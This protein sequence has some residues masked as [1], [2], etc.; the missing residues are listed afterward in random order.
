M[1]LVRHIKV[2]FLAPLSTLRPSV[3]NSS[4]WPISPQ[5]KSGKQ[6]F[7]KGRIQA[8]ILPLERKVGTYTLFGFCCL[9]DLA[10]TNIII[11][12]QNHKET[13]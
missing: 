11:N 1:S 5:K 10:I 7:R 8:K 9:F 2:L 12:Y 13:G 6:A 4:Q 3:S